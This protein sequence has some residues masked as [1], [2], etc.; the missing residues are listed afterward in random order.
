MVYEPQ[1]DKL[2]KEIERLLLRYDW[3]KFYIL[4][5]NLQKNGVD[6]PLLFKN[7]NNLSIKISRMILKNIQLHNI[8]LIFGIL[9]EINRFGIFNKIKFEKNSREI[10]KSETHYS[11]I[12]KCISEL[13][14]KISEPFF[15]FII[16]EFP[17]YIINEFQNDSILYFGDIHPF[18]IE[19]NLSILRD[20]LNGYTMFG[21]NIR[22]ISDYNNFMEWYDKYKKPSNIQG[23]Y[24]LEIIRNKQMLG[25]FPLDLLGNITTISETHLINDSIL[26]RIRQKRDS[27]NF[28]FEF[29]IVSMIVKGGLGPQGKGFAYLTP[30]NEICEICSDVKENKAYILEYKKVLKRQFINELNN[31]IDKWNISEVD[32]EKIIEF[33]DANIQLNII[34]STQID[35]VYNKIDYFFDKIIQNNNQI[36]IGQSFRKKLKQNVQ[37]ILLPIEMQDQFMVRMNLIQSGKIGE[38]EVAKLVSLGDVTHYDMLVQRFFFLSLIEFMEREI[39]QK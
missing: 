36:L 6:I 29:P 21:L 3:N 37:R 9:K 39:S 32:K 38:S 5:K 27:K 30:S 7:I 17:K 26:F 35:Y 12:Y 24:T 28:D 13:F 11:L 10:I 8:N 20:F 31:I 34:D 33:L 2:N 23:Y 4:L 18:G 16:K 15:Y 14:G 19:D 1:A 25:T 22:K